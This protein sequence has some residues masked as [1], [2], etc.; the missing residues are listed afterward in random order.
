MTLE[1]AVKALRAAQRRG[2]KIDILCK[3]AAVWGVVRVE[4]RKFGVKMN[5][6]HQMDKYARRKTRS[7]QGVRG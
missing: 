7:N 1:A 3:L 5:D 6:L 2:I 4:G